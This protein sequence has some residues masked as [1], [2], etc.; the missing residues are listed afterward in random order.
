M[1]Q[2]NNPYSAESLMDFVSNNFVVILLIVIFFLAGFYTGSQW[3]EN[4]MLKGNIGANVAVNPTTVDAG[5]DSLTPDQ[6]AS[7]PEVEKGE[8]IRGDLSKAKVVLVE[9]ADFECPFC[10]RFHPTMEQVMEEYGSDVAWVYRHFPLSFHPNAQSAA[11]ASEC[12][13]KVAGEEG[14][15]KYADSIFTKNGE[16]GGQIS[17]DAIKEAIADATSKTADV[18]KCIDSGEMKDIVTNMANAGGA[19]G[20]NGTPGTFIVVNGEA[21]DLIPGALPYEQVQQ[22]IDANL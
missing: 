10:E 21:K 20:I 13:T 4:K 2:T 12:V 18:Q 3:A 16:L 15:W 9:Y 14:F 5:D 8:H 19:A 22:M 7:L 11:E 17:P 6:L 1:A